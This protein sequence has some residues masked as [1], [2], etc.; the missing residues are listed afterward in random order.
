MTA[1]SYIPQVPSSFG[2]GTNGVEVAKK[3]SSTLRKTSDLGG[4]SVICNALYAEYLAAVKTLETLS[5]P[6]RV[7]V[8]K[9]KGSMSV[10]DSGWYK[11]ANANIDQVGSGTRGFAAPTKVG[12]SQADLANAMTKV[13]PSIATLIPATL[14]KLVGDLTSLAATVG[15]AGLD[16]AGAIGKDVSKMIQIRGVSIVTD[17]LKELM[18]DLVDVLFAPIEALESFFE[19]AG[20]ADLLKTLQDA[21]KCLTNKNLCGFDRKMF[22]HGDTGKTN[23]E[24]YSGLFM[25]DSNGEVDLSQAAGFDPKK[26]DEMKTL[27]SKFKQVT[28]PSNFV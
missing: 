3:V 6:A 23:Y 15:K 7:M 28:S 20:V 27:Y 17:A 14:A 11:P 18:S 4:E 1:P 24:Y 8:E 16:C 19:E 21:E 5:L 22:L 10:Y 12:Q 13:C 9:V 25:M 26:V 2:I